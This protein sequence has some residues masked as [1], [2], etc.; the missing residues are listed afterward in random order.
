MTRT[1][2][3]RVKRPAAVKLV[4]FRDDFVQALVAQIE[5]RSAITWPCTRWQ[6]DPV[7]FAR[8]V[9]GVALW[10]RQI[11]ILEACR[12][13]KRVA[14]SSGNKIGKSRT[15]AVLAIWEFC[16]FPQTR[17]IMTSTT[18]HQV[19]D[20]LWRE[21][22]FLLS[23]HGY[24]VDCREDNKRRQE[25]GHVELSRPCPHSAL[26]PEIPAELP[27]NGLRSVDFREIIG[28][29]S[30]EAEAVAGISGPRLRY[31]VDEASGVA[32]AIFDAIEGNRAGGAYIVLFSNPT[33]NDGEFYEAFYNKRE[34]YRTFRV[35]SEETPN[36]VSGQILIPGLAAKEWIDEKLREWGPEHPLYKVRIKGEHAL[37]E[38]GKAF[39]AGAITEAE[40]R[41]SDTE[42][43]GRL[44]IG[45]DPAGPSGTG[46]E[47]AATPRRGLK[48]MPTVIC[49][50]K[51][52][53]QIADWLEELIE[54]LTGDD[55]KGDKLRPL[56]V[57]DREGPIG[58]KL[59]KELR[60]RVKHGKFTLLT[61]RASDAAHRN[62]T[63]YDRMRDELAGNLE[64]W[65]REGGAIPAD[66]KLAAELH[67]L[68]WRTV[69]RGKLKIT[70][71]DVVKKELKRS[72]DR[73]DSLALSCWADNPTDD[74]PRVVTQPERGPDPP[75]ALSPYA[76]NAMNERNR[77][78]IDP[79]G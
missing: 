21:I 33:R 11:E 59:A 45:L 61:V 9:L 24:C 40:Q 12:D 10:S 55:D 65:F 58:S 67:V 27:H 63:L 39:S 31:I 60:A 25:T 79:Y 70:P 53:E 72:P 14:V 35:S 69:N 28:F 76:G 18:A 2:A 13:H 6:N 30:R 77:G 74:V 44:V 20:I 56:V 32:Q 34:F 36:A 47:T 42:P 64:A 71:K 16:C 15:A 48:A 37:N 78:S 3:E 52:E 57:L 62:P 8:D 68:E 66:T 17:V 75:K 43:V 4:T 51:D 7:G 50:G 29:T 54:S 22:R 73:Y 5:A 1:A 23:N 19:K 49:R 26:I 46:D 38:D 41:W